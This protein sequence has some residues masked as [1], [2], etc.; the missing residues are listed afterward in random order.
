MFSCK[1]L[2]SLFLAVVLLAGLAAPVHV[3]ASGTGVLSC[4]INPQNTAQVSVQLQAASGIASDDATLYL[5]ALPT[6]ADSISGQTPVASVPY[7]G[8]GVYTFSTDLNANTTSSLL[9]SKFCV[10]VRSRGAYKAITDGNYITNPEL[11]ASSKLPR[12]QTSSKKG[13]HILPSFT[14]DVEELNIKQGY[15][16]ITLSDFIS[17]SATDL[18]YT[19]NGKT[20]Y[21]N[22]VVKEYDYIISN[23]SKAG[24][25]VTITL[26]NKYKSGYEY[27]LHPGVSYREGTSFYAVNTSTQQGLEVVSAATHFLAERY[28]GTN[29]DYGKVD[30]W[31]VG[32]EV[33]DN[34]LYYYMGKQDVDTFVREYLQT[35]RV[36]YTAVKSAYANANVYI[37]LQHRWNTENSTGDYG[38]K[39]FIDTFNAYAKAQGDIDWGLSY[40]PYSF[41]MNDADILN[42]GDPSTDIYGNSTFGGEVTDSLTT[43]LIT[44]KNLSLLTDYFHNSSLLN[45]AGQVRSIILGEQGYTSNSNITGKNEAKQAANIALAYYIS[46]M[47]PD[48]DAFLLRGQCDEVEGSEYYRFGLWEMTE[49]G[50]PSDPKYAYEMY[51]YIDSTQSL[52]YTEFAKDALDISDW[53]Q[54]VPGWNAR[55]FSSMGTITEAPLY[56]V[57]GSSGTVLAEGML[58]QWEPGFNVFDVGQFDYEFK[59]YDKGLA[60]ANSYAFYMD[61]QSVEKRF[62]S[63]VSAGSY[64]TMKVNFKPMDATG[65]ADKLEV[66]VRLHSGNDIFTATGI[67]D[68]NKDYT[69]S[70]DLRQ[71]AGRSAVDLVEVLIR[72]SGQQK[73]FAGTFTVYDLTAADSV[74]GAGALTG[75][76]ASTTDLSGATLDYQKQFDYTGKAIE[77]E[78]TVTLKGRPLTRHVDYDVI[79]N[80]NLNAGTGKITVVGI[81]A[82]SGYVTGTFDIRGGFP[83]VYNGIDYAPVYSYGYYKENNP[84]AVAEVGDDPMALLEHFVTKGMTYALQGTGSFNVLAYAKINTDLK[85]EFGSDWPAYYMH[86]LT[87]GIAEGRSISGIQ[88]DDMVPPTYPVSCHMALEIPGVEPTCLTPGTSAGSKC[89]ICGITLVEQKPLAPLGHSYTDANDATCNTCG[90]VR[91]LK[92]P[93]TPMYRLYNPNSG[94]HFYTGSVEEVGNLLNAA[95]Q[96]EGIAWNAPTNS[97]APVYRLYN[98]NNSDHH[99]TTSAEERDNL[100]AVGWKYEGVAWNSAAPENK[101]STPLYRLYNPNADCGSHHYTGSTDERDYLVSLGWKYEGIGWHGMMK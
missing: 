63:P 76:A 61:R 100:V 69:L 22:P 90:A 68:V 79:Y 36:M 89:A 14:S 101:D 27:L 15:F 39:C 40:H 34:L 32:N 97:G 9:Y 88:P 28:S 86:Y 80:S 57:S 95:W 73:S 13:I 33:N 65:A 43:P 42:D 17:N 30:N 70:L 67:V 52:K 83:T 98:P 6:Y 24:V 20:Y 1:R 51:K 77:P 2:L 4:V 87:Q 72:E 37:C 41:P 92:L 78:V 16:N 55:K 85:R 59:K 58:N 47:N 26:L 82:Y 53:S 56:T 99:Y 21:F 12:T 49:G 60:V 46:E 62:D 54:V 3:S 74:A 81:G 45:P 66:N 29:A 7:T 84:V 23:L 44:M 91:D 8:G 50:I 93:T 18:S 71:W 11:I 94:E 25:A 75:T 96:Y 19:Y 5:F 38:G 31:I 10:G 64:L 35:F 48:I